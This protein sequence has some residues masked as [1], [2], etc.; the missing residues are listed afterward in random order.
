MVWTIN[1]QKALTASPASIHTSVLWNQSSCCP[2]SSIICKLA[3]AIPSNAKPN[4]SNF[5]GLSALLGK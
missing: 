1:I 2:R 5:R 3:S 4:R